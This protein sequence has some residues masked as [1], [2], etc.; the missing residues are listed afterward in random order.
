MKT[1]MK[2]LALASVFSGLLILLLT[3]KGYSGSGRKA[4]KVVFLETNEDWARCSMENCGISGDGF[5]VLFENFP[6]TAKLSTYPIEPGIIF[7]Q[8]ILSWNIMVP[9]DKSPVKFDLEVSEDGESWYRFD[10]LSWGSETPI[11]TAGSQKKIEG[12][13][14]V[15]VDELKLEKPMRYAR[16]ALSSLGGAESD[17]MYL[18]RLAFCFSSD[19]A[20]WDDYRLTHREKTIESEEGI[21][22]AV[23]YFTQRSLE[24]NKS[25]GACSPTSTSMA[26]NY[27]GKNV[28]PDKFSWLAY[29]PIN[30]IFG[31]WPFNTQAAYAEGLSKS[32]VD[33]HCGFDEIYPEI[34]YG[35]PV[36]I[37]IAFGYDELPNSPIHE[38]EVG[39]LITVIGF[40]G[41]DKVICND[42][43]GHD[44]DDGIVYYPRKEL[45]DIWI[46]HGGVAYHLWP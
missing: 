27:Y 19:D 18:R 6:G 23:P 14:R 42:P 36:V 1:A 8:L 30:D 46:G 29:D 34:A 15:S 20:N 5:S 9:G 10:Y 7:K 31:N 44:L 4:H 39:H 25:G 37:S 28:D 16:A 38:A 45:E 40:E 43:A 13:G 11:E 21:K 2:I 26:L 33:T 32:W 35:K 41:S 17:I 3:V 22:L 12:I 24:A